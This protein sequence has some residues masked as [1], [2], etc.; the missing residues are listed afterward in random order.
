M[1]ERR[2]QLNAIR[3]HL[4]WKDHLSEATRMKN[5]TIGRL[6]GAAAGRCSICRAVLFED[7]VKIGQMA[8]IIAKSKNGPRGDS[9]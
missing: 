8:H 2:L 3:K 6:F 9:E 1:S 5:L 4:K 7:E